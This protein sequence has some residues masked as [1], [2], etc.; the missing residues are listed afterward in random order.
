[1]VSPHINVY[2]VQCSVYEWYGGRGWFSTKAILLHCAQLILLFI[3]DFIK[4]N[5]GH[6]LQCLSEDFLIS[7]SIL[8]VNASI[9]T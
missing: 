2:V 8:Q 3:N 7:I 5:S 4:T 1:M 9:L 6:H